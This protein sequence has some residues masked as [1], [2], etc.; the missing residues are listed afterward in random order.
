MSDAVVSRRKFVAA[1]AAIAAG[2]ALAQTGFGTDATPATTTSSVERIL[3]IHQ[4]TNYWGRSDGALV[5]HQK[6]MGVTHTIL[7]PTE[8]Q[9]THLG[10]SNGLYAGAGTTPT[11]INVVKMNPGAYFFA[12]NE[13]PDLEGA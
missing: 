6:V 3:D 10:R 1:G 7:P 8:T 4:H 13:V 11:C 2:A 12:A 5:H 9:S